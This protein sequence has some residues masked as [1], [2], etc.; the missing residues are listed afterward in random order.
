M[1]DEMQQAEQEQSGHVL[2]SNISVCRKDIS[3]K[4]EDKYG[5]W[6]TEFNGNESYGWWP[7]EPVSGLY[8]TLAGVN[9]ELNGQTSFGGTATTDPHHG[10]NTDSTLQVQY[11]GNDGKTEATIINEMRNFANTYN[12]EWR[13]TFGWGQNCHTFQEE[14]LEN[15][16]LETI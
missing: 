16:N 11:T 7:L 14:M 13:W 4:G 8:D 15:S 3:P 9:G 2:M 6:W 12:G 1:A 10:D 5:H